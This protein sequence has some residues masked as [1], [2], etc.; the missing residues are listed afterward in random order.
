[1]QLSFS[2]IIESSFWENLDNLLKNLTIEQDLP[3]GSLHVYSNTSPKTG[4]EISKSICIYEPDYPSSKMDVDNPGKNLVV[5]NIQTKNGFEFLIRKKQYASLVVPNSAVVK[6][7]PSDSAFIHVLFD[8]VD[9]AV[10][11]YI[12]ENILYCLS[13]YRSKAKSFGCCSKYE[14]CSNVMRCIHENRL[15]STA[16]L[17][18]RNLESGRIFYGI[19]KNI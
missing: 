1:M 17:Y 16:C 6:E 19:N 2:D 7:I 15:Y 8:N 10:L 3:H 13:K 4:K 9:S 5:M 18:R 14:E 11:K 12:Q